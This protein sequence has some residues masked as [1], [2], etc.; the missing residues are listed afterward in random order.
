M[1]KLYK[2]DEE[3]PKGYVMTKLHKELGS[4]AAEVITPLFEELVKETDPICAYH[5]I[6]DN[7]YQDFLNYILGL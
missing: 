3:Y 4:K 2:K 1:D 7:A 6:L 5:I